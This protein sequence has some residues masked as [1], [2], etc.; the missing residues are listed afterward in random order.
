L[1]CFSLFNFVEF[2]HSKRYWPATAVYRKSI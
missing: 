2:S 1:D